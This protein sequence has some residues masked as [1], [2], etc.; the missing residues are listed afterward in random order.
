MMYVVKKLGCSEL[1]GKT[2]VGYLLGQLGGPG[3]WAMWGVDIA[4]TLGGA[5]SGGAA[6]FIK[7]AMEMGLKAAVKK[8]V[9]K[10]GMKAAISF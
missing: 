10:E 9:A 1:I 7:K 4:I 8:L 3:A 2:I 5:L 6:V